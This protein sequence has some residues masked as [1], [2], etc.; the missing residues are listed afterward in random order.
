MQLEDLITGTGCRLR[1][2]KDASVRIT[3][4]VEDSRTSVPGCLFIAKPGTKV[5]GARFIDDALDRGAEAILVQAGAELPVIPPN[6]AILESER[7]ATEGAVLAERFFGSPSEHLFVAGVTGTNGKTT[8]TTLAK[9]MLDRAGV[10]TGLIGTITIDD[11]HEVARAELTTPP[12]TEIA[13]T[14]ASMRENRCDAAMLE[15]SSHALDQGRCDGVRFSAA[16][17]TNLSG[18]HL[19]YHQDMETYARAKSRL[20]ELLGDG[21]AIV[22]ADDPR[23]PAMLERCPSATVVRCAPAGSSTD[24]DARVDIVE[25]HL[26]RLHL[27]L[28]GPW[29]VC[30]ANLHATGAHNATNAL[31]ACC[32]CHTYALSAEQLTD[33]LAH[34]EMPPGRLQRISPEHDDTPD[35]FVDYAH[36]D[37]AL[38]TS[39]RCVREAIGARRLCVV[40]GCGGDRDRSKRPRMG[41][42]A[43]EHADRVVLTTDNPRTEPPNAIIDDVLCGL[44]EA[45]RA[46]VEVHADRATAIRSAIEQ[47]SPDEVVVIAGKGHEREQLLPDAMG[48]IVRRPFDDAVVARDALERRAG[49]VGSP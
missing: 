42:V 43:I 40:F 20:F 1:S 27:R 26:G 44:N 36:T 30:D 12:A 2:G 19:D 35:V 4:V 24:A 49:R 28:H 45:Q 8:V 46:R 15:C 47:A 17:F 7:I 10:K 38:A 9:S 22:N 25:Q 13:R 41:A 29:G 21:V 34:A 18:D 6:V 37:D 16:V 5:D 39:L 14:L 31:F 3:D 48:G 23:T 33:A 11:G 32:L